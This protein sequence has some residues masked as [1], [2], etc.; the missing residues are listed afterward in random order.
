VPRGTQGLAPAC[1]MKVF[2]TGLSPAPVGLSRPFA[3]PHPPHGVALR[4]LNKPYNPSAHGLTTASLVWAPGPVRS[5]LLRASPPTE[6][7]SCER[8]P[9]LRTAAVDSA[10]SGYLDVSVP[11]VPPSGPS[12]LVSSHHGRGVAPFG[13]GGLI[14][15]MQLPHH[16]SPRSASFFGSWPLGIHPAP[17]PA[18][19]FPPKELR[20][21]I[22]DPDEHA[23]FPYC[24]PPH[25]ANVRTRGQTLLFV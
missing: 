23:A 10:S 11:P 17:S 3:Y 24:A 4:R 9:F 5:P 16:V 22:C 12:P 18:W 13:I 19:R 21:N 20:A 7:P 25:S 1:P 15:C 14:A 6:L 8:Q 2:A